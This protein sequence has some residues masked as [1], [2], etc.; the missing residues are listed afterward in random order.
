LREETGYR[1]NRIFSIGSYTLDYTMFEQ[2]GNLFIAYDLVKEGGSEDRDHG[3]DRNNYPNYKG[4]HEVT[5]RWKNTKCII[6]RG[7][8]PDNIFSS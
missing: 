3:I 6:D 4:D 8:L 7:I 1:A 5:I 2:E